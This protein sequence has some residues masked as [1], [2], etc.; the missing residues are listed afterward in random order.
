[1]HSELILKNKHNSLSKLS[2]AY[3]PHFP[4]SGTELRTSQAIYSC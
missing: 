1:L 2:S 3:S 4:H